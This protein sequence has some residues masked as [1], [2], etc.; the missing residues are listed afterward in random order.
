MFLPTI[1]RRFRQCVN[2]KMKLSLRHLLPTFGSFSFF[3]ADKGVDKVLQKLIKSYKNVRVK[4]HFNTKCVCVCP[5]F[6]WSISPYHC[7]P[8]PPPGIFRPSYSSGLGNYTS[9]LD[10]GNAMKWWTPCSEKPIICS[11][12]Y[13]IELCCRSQ[14]RHLGF[15][16]IY[17]RVWS[18]KLCL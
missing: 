7:S 6:Y 18:I 12:Y 3:Q 1:F 10:D 5:E 17:R 9:L 4:P 15:F 2:H 16:F 11:W 13:S 8:P 14:F